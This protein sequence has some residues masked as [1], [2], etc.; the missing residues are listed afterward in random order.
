MA[1]NKMD[2]IIEAVRYDSKG[3]V[4]LVRLYERRGAAWSDRLLLERKGL[5][6]LLN[7]GKRLATGRRKP[8]LGSMF[9]IGPEVRYSEGHIH[10]D[11]RDCSRDSL[12]G[13]PIF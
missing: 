11:G 8:Y 10:T 13:T 1:R 7:K 5:V 2:G 9:E 6:E 4:D 3:N 12:T